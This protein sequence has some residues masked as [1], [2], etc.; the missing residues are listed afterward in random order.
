MGDD[1][2]R[3]QRHGRC[4]VVAILV[5]MAPV[6]GASV[7]AWPPEPRAPGQAAA[8]S[9]VLTC[10]QVLTPEEASAIVGEGYAGP[11]VNE[12]SPGFTNCEWQGDDTNFGFTFATV[13]KLTADAGTIAE[14]FE[15]NLAAVENADRKRELLAGIGTQAALVALGDD[16]LLLA[17]ARADGVARMI[18]S[19]IARD[20]AIEL[21]R[22]I[23]AP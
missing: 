22:A 1:G 10:A 16:V 2:M 13:Q 8:V 21:A 6:A 12:P 23:A 7:Q 4:A 19:K 3:S 9:P 20:K 17:V 14:E 5:W 15:N 11:A 18:T